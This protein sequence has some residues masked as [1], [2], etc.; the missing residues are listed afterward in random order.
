[1]SENS[2]IEWTDHTFNPWIGCAEVS[3]GCLNCYAAAMDQRRFSKT[4]PGCSKEAPVSHWGK[5]APRYRTSAANWTE[6][7]KWN[8]KAAC[9]SCGSGFVMGNGSLKC[10]DCRSHVPQSHRPRVF[11]ASLAD[12]LDDEV[13]V[14]WLADLL[15]LIHQTPNLDWLLLTKRPE[16]WEPRMKLVLA[17]FPSFNWL[18]EWLVGMPGDVRAGA[19]HN[20]WI[21]ATVE[22]Q[23]RADQRIPHLLS[24]P[25][26]VRF[27][28]CEP[29]L[30]PVDLRGMTFAGE[31]ALFRYWPLTGAHLRDGMNEPVTLPGAARIHWVICGGESGPDA[32]AMHPD[33]ARALRDQCAAARVPFLFKQWG[34]WIGAELDERKGKVI[35]Q[36]TNL[37]QH[38]G[39]IF[40]TNPGHP[41]LKL[42]AMRDHY[43]RTA[44]AR[45]GKKAAG[46]LL[47][48]V[49]HNAFPPAA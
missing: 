32:R 36:P 24:I 44:A 45:V 27:L 42:W 12:W 31:D 6:P 43:W 17:E 5:G 47:D 8:R 34:E 21:G 15:S 40:W 14:R 25:A 39:R 29:L 10:P 49:E 26:N 18:I 46:R 30:G 48:G 9:A 22:D 33:G 19:P 28:S 4:L 11:C 37:D 16:N 1:M 7:V 13:P 35:C 2:P 3:P 23:K 20:V 41:E 38:T